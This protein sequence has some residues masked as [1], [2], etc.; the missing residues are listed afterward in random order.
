MSALIG[1]VRAALFPQ[2]SGTLPSASTKSRQSARLMSR[3][4]VCLRVGPSLG[5]NVP[6]QREAFI[7]R[8]IEILRGG[9]P[10]QAVGFVAPD[11]AALGPSWRLAASLLPQGDRCG[12]APWQGGLLFE[13]VGGFGRGRR[14]GGRHDDGRRNWLQRRHWVGLWSRPLRL[15]RLR[16]NDDRRRGPVGQGPVRLCADNDGHGLDRVGRRAGRRPTAAGGPA[17]NEQERLGSLRRGSDT[18]RPARSCLGNLRPDHVRLPCRGQ[19]RSVG[20]EPG[21]EPGPVLRVEAVLPLDILLGDGGQ[22]AGCFAQEIRDKRL[23]RI[24]EAR[25]GGGIGHERRDDG[26]V[27][28]A[29]DVAPGGG[30]GEMVAP[31]GFDGVLAAWSGQAA[32]G[33]GLGKAPAHEGGDHRL[34]LRLREHAQPHSDLDRHE[35]LV[36]RGPHGAGGAEGLAPETGTE[37]RAPESSGKMVRQRRRRPDLQP[38]HVSAPVDAGPMSLSLSGRSSLSHV[39]HPVAQRGGTPARNPTGVPVKSG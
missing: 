33:L 4:R 1:A 11:R 19:A 32:P 22:R 20:L 35:A 5:G 8:E 17:R 29:Q 21:E 3:T 9:E 28:A 16:R 14:R 2:F 7:E 37:G 27:V 25:Q 13:D 38:E 34:A 6:R 12:C 18:L 26:E 31:R 23:A 24:G 36:E 15:D 10:P 30:L 39:A